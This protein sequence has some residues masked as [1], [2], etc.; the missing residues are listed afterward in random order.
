MSSSDASSTHSTP[1]ASAYLRQTTWNITFFAAGLLALRLLLEW[2]AGP[3]PQFVA[4]LAAAIRGPVLSVLQH[5]GQVVTAVGGLAFLLAFDTARNVA[6]VAERASLPSPGNAEFAFG[7]RVLQRDIRRDRWWT[8]LGVA[9]VVGTVLAIATAPASSQRLREG[10]N[11]GLAV[12]LVL[13]SHPLLTGT[14]FLT[15]LLPQALRRPAQAA[16]PLHR[17]KCAVAALRPPL[18]RDSVGLDEYLAFYVYAL[19]EKT[20]QVSQLP[21]YDPALHDPRPSSSAEKRLY[22]A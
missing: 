4:Q 19:A 1:V 9:L 13:F 17:R 22:K 10:F 16:S 15:F 5:W 21:G 20:G 18:G 7:L 6:R 8:W 12:F 2:T 11:L 3:A 14:S